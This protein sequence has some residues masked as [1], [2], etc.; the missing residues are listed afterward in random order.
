MLE[1]SSSGPSK[2]KEML[3]RKTIN[4]TQLQL[5]LPENTFPIYIVHGSLQEYG[6]LS[7]GVRENGLA[8][9]KA[10]GLKLTIVQIIAH[11]V[12][13]FSPSMRGFSSGI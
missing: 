11:T 13:M 5:N 6:F 3:H 7:S 12:C 4:S 9:R 2:L 10:N 8:K 1:T